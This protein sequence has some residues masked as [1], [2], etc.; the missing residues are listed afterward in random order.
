VRG[1]A[2]ERFVVETAILKPTTTLINTITLHEHVQLAGR[3]LV[4]PSL[5]VTRGCEGIEIFLMLVAAIGAFPA[6][7]KRRAQ[8]LL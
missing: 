6:G 3:V 2:F 4:S 5:R 1:T 7:L 8:G